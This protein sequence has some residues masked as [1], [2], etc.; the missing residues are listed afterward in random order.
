[1][2]SKTVAKKKAA[3]RPTWRNRQ[4]APT[5]ERYKQIQDALVAKGFLSPEAATGQWGAESVDALKRFQSAQNLEATG[6]L[7]SLS[8]IAM[9]LGPKRDA[10]AKPADPSAPQAPPPPPPH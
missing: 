1:L 4:T 6:K 2:T 8:L 9:G 10:P 3:P 7:D 5:E